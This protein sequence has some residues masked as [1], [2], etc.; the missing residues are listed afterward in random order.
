M[1]QEKLF[2]LIDEEKGTLLLYFAGIVI[3]FSG[4]GI[5]LLSFIPGVGP[6]VA[7]AYSTF[8]W[9]S[10]VVIGAILFGTTERI[11]PVKICAMIVLLLTLSEAIITATIGQI[12]LIGGLLVSGTGMI[13]LIIDV[14]CLTILKFE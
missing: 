10:C 13:Y 7:S 11:G 8:G 4:Q 14:V 5:N 9:A 12:P 3:T 6:L 1:T 2:G